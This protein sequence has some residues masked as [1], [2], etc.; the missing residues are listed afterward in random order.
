MP[1]V[2]N[3]STLELTTKD[4]KLDAINFKLIEMDWISQ[5]KITIWG[6]CFQFGYMGCDLRFGNLGFCLG[7][8]CHTCRVVA[9]QLS[10]DGKMYQPYK[11]KIC[12]FV[13]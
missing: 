13:S 9:C 7:K 2:A 4:V 11:L 5:R 8:I 1:T 10:L 3:T 6:L 12:H